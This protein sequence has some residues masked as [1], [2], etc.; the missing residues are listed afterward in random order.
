MYQFGY[1]QRRRPELSEEEF[2]ARWR[3]HYQV[4]VSCE[5]F[6]APV[7]AYVQND[8]LADPATATATPR[9]FDAIG[10]FFYDSNAE[11][12]AV[13]NEPQDAIFQDADGFFAIRPTEHFF[14]GNVEHLAGRAKADYKLFSLL[15]RRHGVEYPEFAKAIATAAEMMSTIGVGAAV[16]AGQ[17]RWLTFEAGFRIWLDRRQ[18]A[19]L[20]RHGPAWRSFEQTLAPV[21]DPDRSR[22]LLVR[23]NVLQGS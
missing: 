14:G 12:K 13:L 17:S 11:R 21:I 3:R 1:L 4:A 10:E 5:R 23:E 20:V 22:T 19:D 2:T 15:A 16:A 6:W 18:D 9:E 8:V 7:R